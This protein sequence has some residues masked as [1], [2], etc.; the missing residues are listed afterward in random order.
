MAIIALIKKNLKGRAGQLHIVVLSK[1][2]SLTYLSN[3]TLCQP[4]ITHTVT[5]LQIGTAII[6]LGMSLQPLVCSKCLVSIKQQNVI[7]L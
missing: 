1:S 2:N 5:S 6:L 3:T 4:F 7:M